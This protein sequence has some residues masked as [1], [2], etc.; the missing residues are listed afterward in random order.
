MN[1]ESFFD[2]LGQLFRR[3]QTYPW[4]VVLLELTAI[5]ALIY[6]V[7]RFLR[8]T[9]GAG[10]IKGVTLVLV[11]STLLIQL[12]GNDPVFERLNF[13][14]R[15]F[16]GYASIALIIVF[17][18]ELRRALVRLGEAR[19]FRGSGLRRARAVEEIVG[20]ASYLSKN[21]VGALIAVEREVG[22]GGIVEAG[23][24]LDAVLS[25]GLIETIF[26]PGSA[27]HDMGV[28]IRGDRV[29]AAGVQFPLAEGEEFGPGLGSRHRAAVGLSQETDALVIVVSEESG[30][31]SLAERGRLT[32]PLTID[33]LRTLL[34]RGLGQ[35]EMPLESPESENNDGRRAGQ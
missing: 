28:V 6:I 8:G 22:L 1:A 10:V 21:R 29:V 5:W 17:Q 25:R 33:D 20:A 3:F 14:Y 7:T 34:V 16:L 23:T 11:I 13:L 9:R 31:I 27:L 18:P 12:L 15:N 32:R 2:R 24:R 35:V 4:W 19:L 26:W 30:T